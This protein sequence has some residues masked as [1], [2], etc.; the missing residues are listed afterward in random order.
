MFVVSFV[1][2]PP[3]VCSLAKWRKSKLKCSVLYKSLIEELNLN[4]A[5]NP[6]FLQKFNRRT[7][8]EFSTEPAILPNCCYV[9]YLFSLFVRSKKF[10]SIEVY[11]MVRIV[12]Y[13]NFGFPSYVS[14]KLS[15]FWSCQKCCDVNNISFTVFCYFL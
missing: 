8:L 7:E 15:K 2:L 11:Q 4:L 12:S 9:M 5:L 13:P 10:I 14:Y 3:T 6:P 1:A